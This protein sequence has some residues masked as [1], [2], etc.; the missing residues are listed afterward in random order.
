MNSPTV[1][2]A[3]RQIESEF[4]QRGPNYLHSFFRD[5]GARQLEEKNLS[6][7]DYEHY[8]VRKNQLAGDEVLGPKTLHAGRYSEEF[9]YGAAGSDTA[10]F[11]SAIKALTATAEKVAASDPEAV[12]YGHWAALFWADV[13]RLKDFLGATNVITEIAAELRTA[14]FQFLGKD[15]PLDFMR[16]V[17]RALRLV[18][19]A[20]RLDE[21]LVDLFVETLE[22]AG[23][24]S[25]APDALRDCH[26]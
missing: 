21:A 25:F 2:P 20:K 15:T 1:S 13:G 7:S 10:R 19:D 24:D 11:R 4:E 22:A 18:A 16:A 12:E 5:E 3:A 14:R 26:G 17:A 23:F 6:P 9:L 8:L